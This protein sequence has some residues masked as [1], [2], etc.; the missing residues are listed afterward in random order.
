MAVKHGLC[1]LTEERIQAFK[2]K[3]MRKLLHI[4]FLEHKINKWVQSKINFLVGPQELLLATVKRQTLAWFG[5]HT[6]WQPLQSHSSGHLGG[7]MIM[8]SAEEMLAGRQH[9]RVDI[10]V[11]A[12]TA[13]KGFLQKRQEEDLCWIIP[14]VPPDDPIGQAT[15]MSWSYHT[16][17]L[18]EVG[19]KEQRNSEAHWDKTEVREHSS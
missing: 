4:F 16:R 13:H 11:Y 18:L 10:P 17:N 1:L 5:H 12:R 6:P 7:W 14:H 9:Q 3:C 8:W 19:L 15:K 2:T